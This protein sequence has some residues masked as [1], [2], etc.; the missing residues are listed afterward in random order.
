M[1]PVLA[2]LVAL[3]APAFAL[4]L[5]FGSFGFGLTS[6]PLLPVRVALA[7]AVAVPP[8]PL[9]VPPRAFVPMV[10]F[11]AGRGAFCWD[12]APTG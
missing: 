9:A 2:G 6:E 4:A 1:A 10:I 12:V 3:V 5:L 11:G 7:D 8:A